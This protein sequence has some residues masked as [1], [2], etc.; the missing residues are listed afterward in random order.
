MEEK[1]STLFE[2]VDVFLGGY[3]SR[4]TVK[5]NLRPCWSWIWVQ[6]WTRIR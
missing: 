6:I 2:L 3:N 1:L 5:R 4:T